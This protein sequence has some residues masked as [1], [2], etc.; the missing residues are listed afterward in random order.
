MT[1]T[2]IL[3]F[4]ASCEGWSYHVLSFCLARD[5]TVDPT[6]FVPHFVESQHFGGNRHTDDFDQGH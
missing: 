2:Q 6:K 5:I 3:W 4:A 1:T